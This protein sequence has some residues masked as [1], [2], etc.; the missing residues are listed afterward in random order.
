MNELKDLLNK[1]EQLKKEGNDIY[2]EKS[3]KDE[4]LLNRAEKKYIECYQILKDRGVE[5]MKYPTLAEKYTDL[6]KTSLMNTAMM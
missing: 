6:M 1:A 3:N 4:D 2:G 5:F